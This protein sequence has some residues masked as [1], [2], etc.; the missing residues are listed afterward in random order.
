[1]FFFFDKGSKIRLVWLNKTCRFC[2][3]LKTKAKL[4]SEDIF[5]L[6]VK[7][8][9]INLRHVKFYIKNVNTILV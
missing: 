6:I 8:Y 5:P 7:K 4:L 9:S 2:M 1:M 3:H